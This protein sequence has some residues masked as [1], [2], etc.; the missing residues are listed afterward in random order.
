MHV[1][2]AYKNACGNNLRSPIY[3]G[4]IGSKEALVQN[5][6]SQKL[7]LSLIALLGPFLVGS[8]GYHT[9]NRSKM[10]EMSENFGLLFGSAFQQI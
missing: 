4:Y 3:G 2:Y 9:F 5:D 7:S 6:H 8:L 10:G 1:L